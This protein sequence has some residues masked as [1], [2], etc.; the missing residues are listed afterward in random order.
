MKRGEVIMKII[1]FGLGSIGQRHASMLKDKH[2]VYAFRSGKGVQ[3]T[4][5]GIKELKTWKEIDKAC[6]SVAFITNP[7]GCHI[8][9]ALECA[10]RG[11]HLFIEKPLS[12]NMK[13]IDELKRLEE[14]KGITVYVAYPFRHHLEY[15]MLQEQIR[16][17]WR[18][19]IRGVYVMCR[20]DASKWPSSRTLQSP[21][22]ELSHEIDYCEGLFGEIT[23]IGGIHDNQR[24]EI[25][26]IHQTRIASH[27]SLI[28][29]AKDELRIIEIAVRGG[30]VRKEWNITD[31]IYRRQQEYFLS[32][33]AK[34]QKGNLEASTKLLKKI[35]DFKDSKIVYKNSME[36][37]Q[38]AELEDFVRIKR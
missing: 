6:P 22:L 35:I 8:E 25:V 26:L 15:E 18:D 11:M 24:A 1:F 14:S 5:E 37:E 32:L 3:E 21:L 13:R 17:L 31:D 2:E 34:R 30:L 10:A 16:N 38:I 28:M 27:L 19:Q 23:S 7:T 36:S 20:T 4:P 9:T 29:D 33:I 12:D